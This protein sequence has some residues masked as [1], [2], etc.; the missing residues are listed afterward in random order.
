MALGDVKRG[1]GQDR[2]L[3][4]DSWAID[5][6]VKLTG[7]DVFLR[8]QPGWSL[9][10][11]DV[12]VTNNLSEMSV[13]ELSAALKRV[14]EENFGLVRVRGEISGFRGVQSSGHCYFSLKDA[15]AK[16][17]VVIW[18]GV[19]QRLKIKPEE[20]ME[21]VVT[22][23]ITTFAGK[24]T[25]QL[26]LESVTPAGVGA[27]MAVLEQRR[28]KLAAEGLFAD[29]RKRSLLF[30]PRVVGVVTSPD[31]AAIRDILHR[32]SDRFPV[33][34]LIW[35]VRVQGESSATEI[36]GAIEG[37]NNIDGN[38]L[39]DRPDVIILARGGGSVEDLWSF[40]E[41]AVVRAVAASVVPIISAIGHET[42]WTLSDFAADKRA[43]TPSAAA[44]MVVPVR[45]DLLAIVTTT[46][47]RFA[48]A[49]FGYHSGKQFAYKNLARS[50]RSDFSVLGHHRQMVDLST[51][52]FEGR[53]G[54][55]IGRAHIGSQAMKA[56]L[57][58]VSLGAFLASAREC[59]K[60]LSFRLTLGRMK[61]GAHLQY[62]LDI[63]VQRHS[64]G[65]VQVT[66]RLENARRKSDITHGSVKSA[67]ASLLYKSATDLN[68]IGKTLSLFEY[69]RVLERGF[70]I[71]RDRNEKIV[72]LGLCAESEDILKLE[73]CDKIVITYNRTA[74]M[75][76][77]RSERPR[78]RSASGAAQSDIP[79]LIVDK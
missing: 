33:R 77:R 51:E 55:L 59:A 42:D 2:R 58:G 9:Q 32:L 43:P 54:V 19:L 61:C 7:L 70:V 48:R 79:N 46:A 57:A 72:R 53:I 28:G 71:V 45:V 34:V 36:I 14:V 52:R 3:P 24:S 66:N 68:N 6:A 76:I 75:G 25:Y 64:T 65:L 50:H 5:D 8:R 49:I 31:G 78:S 69:K 11:A 4:V 39:I 44:E 10:M 60:A 40:S 20:G 1:Q 63:L 13:S 21:I 74:E 35:P 62:Q 67:S 29:A 17:D 15:N 56:R 12:P 22:G 41:E 26:V 47:L 23:K 27:L 37:F 30:L 16:I 38:S 73:F 18:K